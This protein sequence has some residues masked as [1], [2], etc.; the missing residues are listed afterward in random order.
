MAGDNDLSVTLSL[1][2]ELS[3][4]LG[5]IASE[6]TSFGKTA[7]DASGLASSA[8]TALGSAAVIGA[9]VEGVRELSKAG[10][11]LQGSLHDLSVS[12]K[13]IGQDYE[14]WK[15]QLTETVDALRKSTQ[16]DDSDIRR[17]LTDL[18]QF[19][20]DLTVSERALASVADLA[21]ARH[22]SFAQAAD[23]L[24]RGIEGVG[25]GLRQY[26]IILD[27]HEQQMLKIMDETQR[28]DYLQGKIEAH[29]G[30][31]AAAAL[32]TFDGQWAHLKNTLHDFLEE[33]GLPLAQ[34]FTNAL[35]GLNAMIDKIGQLAPSI[36]NIG[37][38]WGFLGG[39]L[40]LQG[41]NANRFGGYGA[42][43]SWDQQAPPQAAAALAMMQAELAFGQLH[44]DTWK[45][46]LDKLVDSI[47]EVEKNW[48][49]AKAAGMSFDAFVQLNAAHLQKLSE[50]ASMGGIQVDSLATSLMRAGDALRALPQKSSLSDILGSKQFAGTW[51]GMLMTAVGPVN[52]DTGQLDPKAAKANQQ[53][54]DDFE[55]QAEAANER[56]NA[57]WEQSQLRVAKLVQSFY[58]QNV[59]QP[60]ADAFADLA[61][62]GGKNLGQIFSA[63]LAKGA[64]DA[65]ANIMD[66][67]K[68]ITIPQITQGPDG[69][70]FY[71]GT[72]YSGPGAQGN[73]QAAQNQ[74]SQ[75]YNNL[76][77]GAF[78]LAGF[79]SQ[80]GQMSPLAGAVS[81]YSIGSTIGP[82]IAALLGGTLSSLA[83]GLIG[84]FIGAL[85]AA[86]GEQGPKIEDYARPLIKNGVAGLTDMA[87]DILTDPTQQKMWLNKI[88][89]SWDGFT[90]GYVS[91]LLHAPAAV[92]DSVLPQV[93]SILKQISSGQFTQNGMT[94]PMFSV[95]GDT[96]TTPQ[97][98]Q[99][100]MQGWVDQTLP[101]SIM[102]AFKPPLQ[103]MFTGMGLTVDKFDEIWTKAEG[104]DPKAALQFLTDYANVVGTMQDLLKKIA[105]PVNVGGTTGLYADMLA[106]NTQSFAQ[107]LATTDKQIIDLG[108]NVGLLTGQ[109]QI[110]AAKQLNTLIQQRYDA[111]KQM[112]QQIINLIVGARQTLASDVFG[113]QL[114]GK[115]PQA[116]YALYAS[117]LGSLETQLGSAKNA[118]QANSIYQQ[119]RS[120]ILSMAG[121]FP[122]DAT[123]NTWAQSELTHEESIFEGILNR[124][125]TQIDTVNQA[126]Q[127]QMQPVIDLFTTTTQAFSVDLSSAADST[128]ALATANASATAS[129][130][131]F[132]DALDSATGVLNASGFVQSTR[133]RRQAA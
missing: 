31:A 115:S 13:A 62:T 95:N 52:M 50:E 72:Q 103:K 69:S 122:N 102:E 132:R 73:A 44:P 92:R 130:I 17:G 88:Q 54:I 100:W 112:V 15:D 93:A 66:A 123:I 39:G 106:T 96:A 83:G 48:Q 55:K 81:G 121:L 118:D 57:E 70:Y 75:S 12:I 26:G 30:G 24:A 18:I 71:R 104:M 110:D 28:L 101:S 77:G 58:E 105:Q 76:V 128:A 33:I 98:W 119:I 49:D 116:Q 43:G 80:V 20:G 42:S 60:F 45:S 99:G 111:E 129:V 91:I 79:G 37:E 25:R 94:F 6:L 126:F 32:E 40:S 51:P 131:S 8:L 27:A 125:G 63:E 82:G 90:N 64:K 29:F 41:L 36:S 34:F 65:G 16:F 56:L 108:K 127:N 23:V 97:Q 7:Q 74:D 113:L 124:F 61:T 21:A 68:N 19:T 67:L 5:N 84:A 117:H 2:D 4:P 120:T 38:R 114:A 22:T 3:K 53:A 46:Q 59:I 10:I 86:I 78:M 35:G 47:N 87:G 1:I 107:T 9:A 14:T 85:I 133:Q 109:A 11:E 89:A